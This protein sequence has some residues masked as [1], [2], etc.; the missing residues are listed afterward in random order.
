MA[1]DKYGD[2]EVLTVGGNAD[3]EPI[4]FLKSTGYE[5]FGSGPVLTS[6]ELPAP[7]FDQI[8]ALLR[9]NGGIDCSVW[10]FMNEEPAN[11]MFQ[12]CQVIRREV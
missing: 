5:G 9:E 7:I 4:P 10:T 2:Y 6:M 12:G 11:L 3:A 8:C 1:A